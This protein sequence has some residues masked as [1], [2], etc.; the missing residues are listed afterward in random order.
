MPNDSSGDRTATAGVAAP[1]AGS[2]GGTI[3]GAGT[4][5]WVNPGAYT[6]DFSAFG[7]SAGGASGPTAS[8]GAGGYDF[9]AFAS[10]AFGPLAGG[11]SGPTTSPGAGPSASSGA[12][13]GPAP[14]M[15]GPFMAGPLPGGSGADPSSGNASAAFGQ[16][17]APQNGAAQGGA[18]QSGGQADAADLASLP[19]D[20]PA[21]AGADAALAFIEQ[22]GL[23]QQPGFS[24][25]GDVSQL[26]GD[27]AQ[28]GSA[29]MGQ[30]FFGPLPDT[31]TGTTATSTGADSAGAQV[32]AGTP[33]PTG[34][35]LIGG[36]AVDPQALYMA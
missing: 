21:R 32:L 1:T 3:E 20:A 28:A 15:G 2:T 16:G 19:E 9:G 33:T 34:G 29:P 17:G 23:G 6:Y 11:A 4:W 8:P 24:G 18:A 12:G 22:N 5:T 30:S 14:G 26:F 35:G 13:D 10:G 36:D 27:F 7:Q 25:A 31:A